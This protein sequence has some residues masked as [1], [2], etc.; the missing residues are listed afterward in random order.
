MTAS[1][2]YRTLTKTQ[3]LQNNISNNAESLLK[4]LREIDKCESKATK[5]GT[6]MELQAKLQD[7][8]ILKKSHKNFT[9]TNPGLKVDQI[10]S[11]LLIYS[12]KCPC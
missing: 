2:C 3:C 7:I 8:S 11:N 5:H 10:Y 4:N 6:G 9:S 1:N 12:Y